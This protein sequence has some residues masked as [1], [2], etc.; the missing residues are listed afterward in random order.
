[1]NGEMNEARAALERYFGF[2][3]FRPGQ[4]DVLEAVF[5]G[6]NVLAVLPTGSGKSL[7]YQLPAVV[8]KGLTVVVSPLIALMRDQ[9]RQ[10]ETRKIPAAAL[11]SS[12]S[13]EENAAIEAGLRH[14]RY[15]LLYLSPERLSRSETQLLLREAGIS[16]LAVD[17]AH[18]ISQWGHDFRPEYLRIA[19]AAQ[20]IGEP[21]LLA[22]TATANAP[23]RADIVKKLFPAGPRIFVGSFDRPNLYLSVRRTPN[24]V[25]EAAALIKR[26][27][28]A[29]GIVYCRSRKDAGLLSEHLGR[30][31]ILALPYHAGLE[32]SLRSAY[33]D[34][35]LTHDGVVMVA[36]IA[37]GMG[38]DKANVRFVCHS[39]L[40]D[41]IEAY[42]QEIGR[43][44]RDGLAAETLALFSDAEIFVRE[45]QIAASGWPRER[46]QIEKHKLKALIG[47][48]ETS[49]CRRQVLL[50][51]F[52]ETSE[53]CG[54]CDLCGA[55]FLFKAEMN[56]RR[57]A[58]ALHRASLHL[59]PARLGSSL[60]GSFAAAAGARR[61][62]LDEGIEG[63]RDETA[64]GDQPPLPQ[65]EAEVLEL[66]EL[67]LTA[68][69]ASLLAALKAKRL[70]LARR[71]R[72]P[73]E[74]I[75]P[76]RAL[77]EMARR[78]PKTLLELLDIPGIPAE[79]SALCA[80]G[81]LAIIA[82]H[83]GS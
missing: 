24:R 78:Q 25:S 9:V 53:P 54:N 39:G 14:G 44:G 65:L 26:H 69:Q 47:F 70:E 49:R 80:A 6:Q 22:V 43:A 28:G 27:Q 50:A 21:Q 12:N 16:L 58:S 29:S 74:G 42:Y 59:V 61:R 40:P 73:A 30:L 79:S 82:H 10:L 71:H 45:R 8:R 2:G 1:M 4:A 60:A 18:C 36:T 83:S 19:Q 77:I 11:N 41:S 63:E 15:R 81:F 37:F 62:C 75:A 17:E 46:K 68:A 52:G 32:A 51:A 34:E 33:E 48:C 72:R 57:A 7:C 56:A 23:T 31:G 13:G 35:F 38:I 64:G 76:S 66:N 55:G 5:A 20:A 67:A 3:A